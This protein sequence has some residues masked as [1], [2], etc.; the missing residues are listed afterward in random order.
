M[1]NVKITI[2][3]I[4]S[5]SVLIELTTSTKAFAISTFLVDFYF[6]VYF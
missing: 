1:R 3:V 6:K 4:V 2:N 5:D